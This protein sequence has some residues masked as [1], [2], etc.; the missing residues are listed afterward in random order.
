MVTCQ[1]GKDSSFKAETANA[2]LMN[3][4]RTAFHKSILTTLFHHLRQQ[5]VQR[6][7]IRRSMIGRN[8]SLANV[9]AHGRTQAAFISKRR[10]YFIKKCGNG[11]FTIGSRH[12]DQF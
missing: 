5:L 1:I 8:S 9:I 3:G 4:M 2:F 11:S 12:S 6:D 10:K 7:S